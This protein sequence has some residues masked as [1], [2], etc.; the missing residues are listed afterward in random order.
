M[1]STT[2]QVPASESGI[3]PYAVVT[4]PAAGVADFLGAFGAGVGCA[5]AMCERHAATVPTTHVRLCIQSS[6][7]RTPGQLTRAPRGGKIA[8]RGIRAC[9]RPVVGQNAKHGFATPESRLGVA[10]PCFADGACQPEFSNCPT[11]RRPSVAGL[12]KTVWYDRNPCH[13]TD[14]N[15]V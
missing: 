15:F 8:H 6:F 1:L 7:P 14:R 11:A 9:R 2:S 10:K 13:T 12:G 4:S 3:F 5:T